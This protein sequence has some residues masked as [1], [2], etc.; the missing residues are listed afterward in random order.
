M[1]LNVKDIL[2]PAVVQYLVLGAVVLIVLWFSFKQIK[3]AF[4]SETEDIIINSDNP[5]DVNVSQLTY[6]ADQYDIWADALYEAM[7]YLGTSWSSILNVFEN[8]GTDADVR[9][10]IN[11]YGV[12]TLHV[13]GFPTAEMNLPQSLVREQVNSWSGVED[14]NTI[15]EQNGVTLR[16]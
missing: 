1:K 14:V 6:P 15:L 5:L 9:Q 16:F 3:G 7:N 10:L 8:M 2:T 4:G 12:R 13:F 11:A